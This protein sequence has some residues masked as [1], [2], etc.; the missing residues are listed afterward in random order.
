MTVEVIIAETAKICRKYGA[1]EVILYERKVPQ[2][3]A[4]T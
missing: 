2:E 1:K 3:N 4:V